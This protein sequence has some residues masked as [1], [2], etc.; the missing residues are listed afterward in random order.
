[1]TKQGKNSAAHKQQHKYGQ[2]KRESEQ[3]EYRRRL[4]QK[5]DATTRAYAAREFLKLG[6]KQ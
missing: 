4:L 5:L 6:L 1:M 2:E 3:A